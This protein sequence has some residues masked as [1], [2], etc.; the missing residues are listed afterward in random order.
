MSTDYIAIDQQQIIARGSLEVVIRQVKNMGANH[1]PIVF[2]AQS[3]K[4]VEVDWHGDTEEVLA[5]SAAD[6]AAHKA[7]RGRPKLGVI[8]REITLLPCHWEWLSQQPGGASV[9]LRKLVEQAQKQV[10]P[11]ERITRKQQELDKFMLLVAGDT[12]GFEEASRA[13]YR[14]SR[15]SFKKAIHS[16]PSDLKKLV[17][18]KFEEIAEM[19]SGKL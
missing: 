10:S 4:R 3:C 7:K 17:F 12:P 11:E 14:N 2:E 5:V 9:T 1:E 15:I 16:W 8:P 6:T 13:L 19:H 18:S